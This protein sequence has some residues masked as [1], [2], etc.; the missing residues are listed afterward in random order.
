MNAPAQPTW[1]ASVSAC[2]MHRACETKWALK[3]IAKIETPQ[4]KAGEL[5]DAVDSGQLQPYL[6]R[7]REF[8]QTSRAGQIAESARKYLPRPMTPGLECQK[9]MEMASPNAIG[10]DGIAVRGF[11]GYL[12]LWLPRGGI[13]VPGADGGPDVLCSGVCVTDFKTTGDLKW[14]KKAKDLRADW[15]ANLYGTW[16]MVTTGAREI[17]LVWL[18]MRT[19]ETP[20]A[21]RTHVHVTLA[22]TFPVFLEIDAEAARMFAT[23]EEARKADALPDWDTPAT[24]PRKERGLTFA[25][26]LARNPDACGDF[27]G[28]PY[29]GA[30]CPPLS[31]LETI[32]ALASKERNRRRLP[33]I[34]INAKETATNMNAAAKLAELRNRRAAATGAPIPPTAPVAPPQYVM[35][36]PDTAVPA[37]PPNMIPAG[38]AHPVGINPPEAA[39]PPAA[40]IGAVAAPAPAA[41]PAAAPARRGRPRKADAPAPAPV[42]PPPAPVQAPPTA[43]AS[44]GDDELDAVLDALTEELIT[45]AMAHAKALRDFIAF[46]RELTK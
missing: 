30:A 11:L 16:A 4:S 23:H 20:K 42:A 40:P 17:D 33:L 29:R 21:E 36:V 13:P 1:M 22:E 28:C 39:L 35:G 45:T 10:A 31:P 18:Y 26:A 34:E 5:G 15:Q 24:D 43:V 25:R 9:K 14:M 37:A 7:G 2:E 46:G 12:D 6:T 27:G 8:D 19:K 41:P 38:L 3:Y 32:N 44:T